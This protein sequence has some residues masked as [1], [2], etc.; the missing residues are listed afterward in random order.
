M[1]RLQK[2]MA[3]AGVASRRKS[4]GIIAEG[5][6]EVNGQTVTEMGTKVDPAQDVIKVDG[7]VITKEE[8]VYILL[9]KPVGY[10]TSVEDPRGRKTVLDLIDGVDQRIYPVGRL[11]YNSSGILLLTNDGELTYILTH[12]S[13]M[14]DKPYLAKVKGELGSED[15]EKLKNGVE[16]EDG[17]TAPAKIQIR[18]KIEYETEFSLTIHEGRNRQVR[19]MCDVVGHPVK[20]LKRTFFGPLTLEGLSTG[21]FRYLSEKEIEILK[22]LKD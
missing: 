18:E 11:D 5:R 1:D 10:I 4:E 16:L 13:N 21:E 14:I 8:R 12:P 9:Y 6:V 17:L 3:H 19:R 7:E 20:S 22:D 2:V 15:V